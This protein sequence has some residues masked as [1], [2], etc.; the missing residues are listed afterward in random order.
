MAS[1]D[2][3]NRIYG[4]LG[5]GIGLMSWMWLSIV[6]VLLGAEINSEMERQTACDSTEGRPKPLGV[7]DAFAADNVGQGRQSA[8]SVAPSPS[9]PGNEI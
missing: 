7:R 9:R 8:A 2:S 4:S 1:F 6:V 3:Y 5:A